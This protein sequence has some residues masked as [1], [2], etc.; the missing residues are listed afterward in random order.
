MMEFDFF[1][2][3]LK[4]LKSLIQKLIFICYLVHK[5][6]S[7]RFNDMKRKDLQ[8]IIELIS[9]QMQLFMKLDIITCKGPKKLLDF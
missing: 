2:L 1:L 8:G 4:T 6:F 3:M 5:H 7:F 9:I